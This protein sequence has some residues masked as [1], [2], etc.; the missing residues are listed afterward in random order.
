MGETFPPFE[1]GWS[2]GAAEG[3]NI[4]CTRATPL[5]KALIG[6][7]LPLL[8]GPVSLLPGFPYIIHACVP[9]AC[10]RAWPHR[11]NEENSRPVPTLMNIA[12]STASLRRDNYEAV[13]LTPAFVLSSFLIL[14]FAPFAPFLF[15]SYP[16]R[17]AYRVLTA[18]LSRTERYTRN[19]VNHPFP[20]IKR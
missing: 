5:D 4:L 8:S 10:V 16:L 12:S 15:P 14:R 3:H 9:R 13:S 2:S 17:R 7:F 19:R 6:F 18:K 11:R 20:R 1:R